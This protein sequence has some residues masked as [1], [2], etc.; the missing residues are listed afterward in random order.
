MA[1]FRE[2][3]AN[4]RANAQS[5]KRTLR[6]IK[7]E[8]G[9]MKSE[10]EKV[11]QSS[12]KAYGR[13]ADGTKVYRNAQGQLQTE[14]GKTV[15][16]S[17]VAARE[18]GRTEQVWHN[19]S[20]G[21]DTAR[22]G[23]QSFSNKLHDVGSGM[24]TFGGTLTK[25]ITLP[26]A[27]LIGTAAGITAAF[28]W[29]R[30]SSIDTAQAQLRGLGYESEDV[31]R[32]TGELTEALDGGMMTMADATFATANAMAAGVEEGDELT[33]YIQILDAAVVGGT[34]TFEEMQQIFSRVADEG[35]LTRREFDMMSDRMP[36]FSQAVQDYTGASGQALYDMLNDGKITLDDFLVVMEDHA[37]D[38]ATEY[39][40]TW[41][42]M[43]EN[44]KKKT[45]SIE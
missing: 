34:G 12:Q 44:T 6:G 2:I 18:G 5:L 25:H 43:V 15:T 3:Q 23:V 36:G 45:R 28:G 13:M 19:I 7:S 14:L 27:G 16:A 10:T 37:G 4:F 29:G 26:V 22:Q 42:G 20:S 21:L 32:I 11:S 31:E 17:Q 30:L 1:T 24:A 33:K 41:S 38:M 39:A 9:S 8:M 40:K 35:S